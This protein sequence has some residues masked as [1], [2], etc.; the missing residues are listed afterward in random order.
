MNHTRKNDIVIT[1]DIGLASILV[2]KEV[3]AI[4][5][6]GEL[7][8]EENMDNVLHLRFLSAKERRNGSYS[9]GPKPFIEEHRIQFIKIFKETLSNLAGFTELI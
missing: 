4:S 7:Y 5:P 6:R 8:L 1:Q 2:S 9:K 3:I